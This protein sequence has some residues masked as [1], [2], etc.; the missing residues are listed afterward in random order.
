MVF[1]IRVEAIAYANKQ[2]K[3]G[4]KCKVKKVSFMDL[5]REIVWFVE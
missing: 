4:K 1:K 5:A 3:E 2:R